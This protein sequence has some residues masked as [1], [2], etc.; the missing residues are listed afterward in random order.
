MIRYNKIGQLLRSVKK[1]MTPSET[2]YAEVSIFYQV[3]FMPS[4]VSIAIISLTFILKGPK[5]PNPNM[6]G[7]T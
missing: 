3:L 4:F 1:E 7:C 5:T 2:N 6:A